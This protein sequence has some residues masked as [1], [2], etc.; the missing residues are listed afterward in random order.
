MATIDK[1]TVT[2]EQV[3]S[4]Y[5]LACY[6][7]DDFR[8]MSEKLWYEILPEIEEYFVSMG[9]IFMFTD[10]DVPMLKTVVDK[11]F[12]DTFGKEGQE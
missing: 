7:P 1:N 9:R 12:D 2:A 11:L 6:T 10:G 5:I 4:E 3:F 8:G